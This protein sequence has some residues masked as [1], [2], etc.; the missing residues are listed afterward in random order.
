MTIT[1]GKMVVSRNM[2]RDV[3]IFC[4]NNGGIKKDVWGHKGVKG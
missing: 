1:Q 4:L 2:P 3:G